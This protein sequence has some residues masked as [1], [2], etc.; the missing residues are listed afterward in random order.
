MLTQKISS[1]LALFILGCALGA[2]PAQALDSGDQTAATATIDNFD[3]TLLASMKDA[4]TLGYQGRFNRL[5]PVVDKTFDLPLMTKLLV[6]P[7]WNGFS[8]DK[9]AALLE[10]FRRYTIGTY[11]NRFDSYD[12]EKF[13]IVAP[14]TAQRDDM[15]VQTELT[16]KN[17]QPV[18]LDYILRKGDK[19][20]KI[21]DIFLQGTISEIATQRAEFQSVLSSNGVDGLIT[22]L[23]KKAADLGAPQAG[24]AGDQQ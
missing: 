5:A 22:T 3:N 11:A 19:G 12:G 6:G 4:K 13:Q 20:W 1:A 21:I 17:G 16:P 9:Q 10:Q 18:K 14:A 8:P 23:D 24:S 15:R 2:G 7:Q